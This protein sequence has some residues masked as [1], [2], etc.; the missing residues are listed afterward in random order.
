M[1]NT[2][3]NIKEKSFSAADVKWAE[4]IPLLGG[5]YCI[6]IT[7]D[8]ESNPIPVLYD[9]KSEAL[10]E[11]KDCQDM[12]DEEIKAGHRDEDDEYEGEAQQVIHDGDLIHL[13][14]EHGN[15]FDSFEWQL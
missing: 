4:L 14:D 7:E 12:Y 3:S 2:T 5:G 6:G 8:S 11:I 1:S 10:D 9:F 15:I 13:C